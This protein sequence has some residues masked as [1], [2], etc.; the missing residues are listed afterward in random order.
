MMPKDAPTECELTVI[1]CGLSGM[2]AALFAAQK[3]ISTV[4]VGVNGGLIFA[5]GYLDLLGIHPMETGKTWSEPWAGIAELTYDWPEHP[6]ARL[7]KKTIRTAFEKV[8]SFLG[9]NGL[10][11]REAGNQN[12]EVMTPLGTIR[13]TYY[14]PETMWEGVRA[15]KEKRPCLI[16]GFEELV[17]FSAAQIAGTLK[18]KW[19]RL[20][21]QNVRLSEITWA[22]PAVSGD[23]L[24]RDMEMPGNLEKLA[25][26]IRPHTGDAEVIGIPAV[27]GMERSQEVVSKLS[28]ALGVR[29]F[30]IPTMP[31][32]VPGLRMNA[33]F[34][35]GL[36]DAGVELFFPER[37]SSWK[38]ESDGTFILGLGKGAASRQIRTEGVIL[39]SGRFWA[40][41]LRADR[42]GIR[43]TLFDLPV[44]QPRDREAWHHQ[45]FLDLQGHPANRAGLSIDDQFRPLDLTGKPAF[46]KLFAAG[47]ILAHQDWIRMKCGS[48]LAISSA[49][50]TVTAFSNMRGK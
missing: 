20:R 3:G 21:W 12:S 36:S 13:N 27:L 50:A 18:E 14:V 24:A 32:S 47:S 30:E 44:H 1:G 26:S 45:Q 34:S 28:L 35:Q 15:L 16:I 19:P 25:N 29:V 46:E 31:L 7:K 41:G 9:E 48:G 38:Q 42:D 10:S 23:I 5:S 40:K 49:Y 8:V 11:Y 17:D 6:Y 37:I 43:E 22:G 39:A 2:A 4:Q 33:V